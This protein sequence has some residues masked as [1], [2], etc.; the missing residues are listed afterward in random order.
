MLEHYLFRTPRGDH[1]LVLGNGSLFN[2][3]TQPNLDYR[4]DTEALVVRFFAAGPVAAG[5]EL[6]VFYGSKLWF[7]DR[8]AG[9][10]KQGETMHEHMDCAETF[11]GALEL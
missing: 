5:Q 7:A 11:L 6:T 3:S 10:R 2:H 9:A 4:V 8:T 1:L